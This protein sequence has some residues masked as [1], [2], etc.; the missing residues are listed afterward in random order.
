MREADDDGDWRA[1]GASYAQQRALHKR[2]SHCGYP[3][4]TAAHELEAHHV[5]AV[6]LGGRTELATL[7]LLCSRHHKV[8][9]DHGVRMRGSADPPTFEDPSGRAITANQ[10]HAPPR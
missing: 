5:V 8:I 9:H 10:P 4:C 2:S 7:I 1:A 6:E 3:A